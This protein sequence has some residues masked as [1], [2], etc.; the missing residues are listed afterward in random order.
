MIEVENCISCKY[1]NLDRTCPAF[2]NG[3]PA[4]YLLDEY[5]KSIDENQIGDY[6]FTR[7][8]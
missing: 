1:Y 2:P 3:I 5:H 4:K 8:S 7:E 6:V